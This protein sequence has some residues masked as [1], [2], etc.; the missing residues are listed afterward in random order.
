MCETLKTNYQLTEEIG[1][2]RFGTIFRCF[3]PN[4]AVPYACK[5]IDKSLL[6]DSTDRHPW[7]V[8]GGETTNQN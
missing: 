8:S 3:H 5:V 1:R 7:I 2:G 6:S 4:S